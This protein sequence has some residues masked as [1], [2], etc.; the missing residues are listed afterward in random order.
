MD[1]VTTRSKARRNK[2][3][4]KNAKDAADLSQVLGMTPTRGN[5]ETLVTATAL[6]RRSIDRMTAI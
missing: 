3:A 5:N 2:R 6:Q 1:G 4:R